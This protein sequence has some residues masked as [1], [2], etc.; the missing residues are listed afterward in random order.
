M[1]SNRLKSIIKL[2]PENS[3]V[4]DVGTDHGYVPA[5]LIEEK[6]SKKVIATDISKGSLNKIIGYVKEK[7]LE[8]FI[9]TRLGNGLEVLKPY[10]VDTVIIAGMGGLLIRDILEN[11]KEITESINTF[12][13]QP[14][15]GAK[16]LREYLFG[17]NFEIVHETLIKEDGKYYEIIKAKHGKD[18]VEKEIYYEIPKKLIEEK[19][20]LLEEY[21]KSKLD[22]AE[23][24]L[25]EI[26]DKDSEK[27]KERIEQLK[28]DI[29]NY[30][31]ALRLVK[32]Q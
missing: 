16:E 20:P 14:M 19:H 18:C 23:N 15:I 24:I 25:E 26:I 12:I 13:L 10:E 1:I 32:S 22:Y 21:I 30:K 8:E 5:Y 9:H 6:K 3:I 11:D 31:E 2:V 27:V 17:N 29:N 4:A 28:T 7:K